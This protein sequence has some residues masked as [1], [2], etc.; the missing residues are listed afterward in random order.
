MVMANNVK[1][2]IPKPKRDLA[3]L[4]QM[5]RE[6]SPYTF[7]RFSDGEIEILRNRK[8][9]IESGKTEF[10]G[11]TFQNSFPAFDRKSFSPENDYEIRAD[12]ISAATFAN[13][14]Y[15]KG[16]PTL[17]NNATRDREF[18]L[19]LSGGFSEQITF[20]DL[21][22][23]SNYLAARESFFPLLA[24][25]AKDLFIV[26]NWRC[27]PVSYLSRSTLIPIP[28]NFFQNYA[29]VKKQ[30]MQT[31]L[32]VPERAVVLSSASSLSNILGKELCLLRP[33]LTFVDVGTALNDLLGLPSNTR[34]YH[35]LIET[36][37][38]ASRLATIR[39]KT[40]RDFRIKW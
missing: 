6:K 35:Q 40:S 5:T 21:L 39:Y 19:R 32:A 33:D 17:S 1:T 30:A 24:K 16:I 34:T 18:L 26:G 9:V 28:D 38:Q 27:K 22:I 37:K 15:F 2:S 31:L 4:V 36:E 23:N 25:S 11:K 14:T 7:V 10:R 20:S 8:L 13:R 12:L 29:E 3:K